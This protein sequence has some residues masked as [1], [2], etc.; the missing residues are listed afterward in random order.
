MYTK[1]VTL[2]SYASV[3][4]AQPEDQSKVPEVT[5]GDRTPRQISFDLYL[6]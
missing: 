4:D 5:I 2:A 6:R 1:D 3:A